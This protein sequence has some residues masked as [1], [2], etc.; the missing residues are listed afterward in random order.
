MAGRVIFM[1]K[2][3]KCLAISGPVSF[4]FAQIKPVSIRKKRT[5]T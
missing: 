1:T 2:E 3:V 5:S 4:T